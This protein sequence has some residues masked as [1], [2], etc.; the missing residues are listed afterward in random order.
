MA[1]LGYNTV[2]GSSNSTTDFLGS[3]FQSPDYGNSTK[4]TWRVRA[5]AGTINAK[6]FLVEWSGAG[7]AS[8]Y[9]VLRA[10]SSEVL[11]I[12]TADTLVDFTLVSQ[13]SAGSNFGLIGWANASF[14]YYFDSSTANKSYNTGGN[15]YPAFPSPEF[16][17]ILS[18]NVLQMFLTYTPF[19]PDN[20]SYK[21]IKGLSSVQ[22]FGSGGAITGLKP[23]NNNIINHEKI[24]NPYYHYSDADVIALMQ[25]KI[26]RKNYSKKKSYHWIG[27]ILHPIRP[28]SQVYCK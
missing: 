21:T 28:A 11:G 17:G 18:A 1:I 3:Y 14:F 4:M 15:T 10:T 13:I 6:C 22:G 23:I 25:E 12:T 27:G 2:A 16:G 9:L 24:I 5:A 20:T 7:T 8:P 19:P 26:D